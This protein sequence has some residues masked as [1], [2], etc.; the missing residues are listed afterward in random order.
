MFTESD[1][2]KLVTL[3]TTVLQLYS[4]KLSEL[5]DPKLTSLF[6]NH[7]GIS[8]GAISAMYWGESPKDI[9]VYA[10][11]NKDIKVISDFITDVSVYIKSTEHYNLDNAIDPK[12]CVTN[13]AIT[14]KNDIQFITLTDIET[15]RK[16]FDFIHCMPWID[17][18]TQKLHISEAQFESI[19]LRNIVLNKT[20][21][22]PKEYR[23]QKYVSK[24][25]NFNS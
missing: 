11:D 8:G 18:K 7:C 15:A 22:S 20:G 14:L 3:R 25:W 19:K 24:G 9:D 23:V 2:T 16:S 5:N 21:Q 10:K 17:I 1:K 13:N 6:F 12:L 4:K